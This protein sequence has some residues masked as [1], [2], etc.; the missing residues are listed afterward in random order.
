M[1]Y[2]ISY[3]TI[4]LFFIPGLILSKLDLFY[5]ADRRANYLNQFYN[6]LIAGVVTYGI[7]GFGYWYF[8][9]D[10]S[11]PFEILLG[12]P[13]AA[14]ETT[15]EYL[16]TAISADNPLYH[17]TVGKEE[18]SIKVVT[19]ADCLDEIAW[20]FGV[21][22]VLSMVWLKAVKEKILARSLQWMKVTDRF[23]EYDLWNE[24]LNEEFLAKVIS[25]EDLNKFPDV[26]IWNYSK[27]LLYSGK[28]LALSDYDT[29]REVILLNVEVFRF[30]ENLKI[31]GP[32]RIQSFVYLS[33]SKDDIWMEFPKKGEKKW[34][35]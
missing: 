33:F 21:S 24:Y 30:D 32:P 20:A 11:I 28:I 8:E 22:C 17:W 12:F 16:G 14:V 7:V 9:Y 5:G 10:F 34:H 13:E 4:L 29:I 35:D 6:V 1:D 2:D 19:L 25:N 27:K 15:R 26:R 23:S 18:V 3:L 31:Y